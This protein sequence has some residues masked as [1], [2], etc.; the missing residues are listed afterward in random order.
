MSAASIHTHV[1]RLTSGSLGHHVGQVWSME[2]TVT[3]HCWFQCPH[4]LSPIL[5]PLPLHIYGTAIPLQA[6]LGF[7]TVHLPT[8]IINNDKLLSSMKYQPLRLL[9]SIRDQECYKQ[10]LQLIDLTQKSHLAKKTS[11]DFGYHPSLYL[12][13]TLQT[14][15]KNEHPQIHRFMLT[16][17]QTKHLRCLNIRPLH[18]GQCPTRP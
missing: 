7:G 2:L 6:G 12:D 1:F 17:H 5:T 3:R 4:C 11:H 16:N 15:I 10:T 14:P 8:D 13:P 18:P 9:Q